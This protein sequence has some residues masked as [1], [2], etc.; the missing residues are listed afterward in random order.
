MS[1]WLAHCITSSPPFESLT[2]SLAHWLTSSLYHWR[3]A[4]C[5]TGSLYHWWSRYAEEVMGRALKASGY[6]RSSYMIATKVSETYLEPALLKEHL[7]AS[8]ERMGVDYIDLY[9]LHWYSLTRS[10]CFALTVSLS[11]SRSLF[12]S[13]SRFSLPHLLPRSVSH[14]SATAAATD[15]LLQGITRSCQNCQISRTTAPR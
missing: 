6:A 12:H 14:R 11:L 15:A 5:L 7:D 3:L 2:G 9:Q 1:H 8:L 4:V 10:H 13:L